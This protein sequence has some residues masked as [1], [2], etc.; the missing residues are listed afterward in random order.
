[1]GLSAAFVVA[2]VIT[3]G[4]ALAI[5][6]PINAG[7]A[8]KVGDPGAAAAISFVIGFVAPVSIARCCGASVTAIWSLPRLGGM[9]M[10]GAMIR[11]PLLVT[12]ILDARGAFRMEAR[13]VDLTRITAVALVASGVVLSRA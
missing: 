2:L 13:P 10:V 9:T 6:G 3:I 7:L 11:G 4:A 1:M 5:H 12:I 8:R